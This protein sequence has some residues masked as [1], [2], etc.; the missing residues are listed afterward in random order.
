MASSTSKTKPAK[1]MQSSVQSVETFL[2]RFDS[3]LK[4]EVLALRQIILDVDPSITEQIKWNVPSFC[5]SEHFATFNLRAK[6]SLGII[7]H[8]G[9]KVRDTAVTGI[10]ISDPESLLEWLG[11]DR[12]IVKFYGLNDIESKKLAFVNVIQQWI[13]HV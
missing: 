2:T 6:D 8:L 9:A 13:Q 10:S 12:A 7:L 3:A 1:K 11:A 4:P 5:T